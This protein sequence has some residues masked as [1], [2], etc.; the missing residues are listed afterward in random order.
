M[1][2]KRLCNDYV[3]TDYN[4]HRTTFVFIIDA[5]FYFASVDLDLFDDSNNCQVKRKFPLPS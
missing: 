1:R 4:G 3:I 2:L 5:K